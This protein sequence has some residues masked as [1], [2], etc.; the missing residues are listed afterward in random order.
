MEIKLLL[1]HLHRP[2]YKPIVIRTHRPASDD[3]PLHGE[4]AS[5]KKRQLLLCLSVKLDD[6]LR[7]RLGHL[8]A[9]LQRSVGRPLIAILLLELPPVDWWH[10][11]VLLPHLGSQEAQ[12]LLLLSKL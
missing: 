3:H 7:A 5:L 10:Q 1:K 6:D 8:P 2:I 11:L 12:A 9:A 4:I